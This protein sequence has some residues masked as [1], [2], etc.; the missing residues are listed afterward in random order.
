MREYEIFAKEDSQAEALDVLI[1]TVYDY[2]NL[3]AYASKWNAGEEVAA[4]YAQMLGILQDKYNLTENEALE[5]AAEPD[6]VEYTKLVTAIAGGEKYVSDGKTSDKPEKIE[7][8]PD[9]LPEEKKFPENNGG[10]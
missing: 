7:D 8:L 5:I 3:Y 10:Q 4:V 9:M 1:Q 2:A 6:D